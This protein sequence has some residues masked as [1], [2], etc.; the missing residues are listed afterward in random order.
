MVCP[1]GDTTGPRPPH[2][3]AE[4]LEA[5]GDDAGAARTTFARSRF[6]SQAV[7]RL[8]AA[9]AR[10][11]HPMLLADDQRRWVTGNAAASDLLGLAAQEIPWRTMDD[12]TPSSERSRL[13]QQ[14]E[15]FLTNGAAEG[16]YQLYVPGRGAVPV[17]FSATANVLPARHLSLFIPPRGRQPARPMAALTRRRGNRS[18][19]SAASGSS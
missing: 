12:Y 15:E 1:E 2:E 9:F 6:G 19:Q 7:L 16:W 4:A 10:S 5:A 11:A 8:R 17:E 18:C 13:E 14:W 3:G